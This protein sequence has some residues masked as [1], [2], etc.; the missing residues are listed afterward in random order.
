MWRATYSGLTFSKLP[1]KCANALT[2]ASMSLVAGSAGSTT[3]ACSSNCTTEGT[4]SLLRRI[5][6][7][8]PVEIAQR[9]RDA[10]GFG[11]PESLVDRQRLPQVNDALCPVDRAGAAFAHS[12]P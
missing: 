7:A 2:C 1:L 10:I 5:G 9:R 12:F 3:V 11:D 6:L 4:R 8:R